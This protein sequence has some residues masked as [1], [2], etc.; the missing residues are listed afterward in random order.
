MCISLSFIV[1]WNS[2]YKKEK[3]ELED[4][5]DKRKLWGN[6][7]TLPTAVVYQLVIVMQEFKE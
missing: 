6:C 2:S 3:N 1:G 7:S 4:R 5:K